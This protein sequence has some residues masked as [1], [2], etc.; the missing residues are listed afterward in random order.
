MQLIGQFTAGKQWSHGCDKICHEASIKLPSEEA[1]ILQ[2]LY[3][4]VTATR[5]GDENVHNVMTFWKQLDEYRDSWLQGNEEYYV[6]PDEANSYLLQFKNSVLWYELTWEQQ[7]KNWSQQ[8]S[9][10]NN[11]VHKKAGW[12]HAAKSIMQYGLPKLKEREPPVDS[13][14]RT[15]DL[16]KLAKEILAD[17]LCTQHARVQAN[18]R[19]PEEPSVIKASD[20]EKTN[21]KNPKK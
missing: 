4:R 9:I 12:V 5:N 13:V 15:A 16:V 2:E 11:I 7:K 3:E 1:D 19:I 6:T 21:K 10:L 14:Q 20:G 17:R 18:R 8:S